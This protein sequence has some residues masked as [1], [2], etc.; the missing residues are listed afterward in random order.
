MFEGD[1]TATTP[2]SPVASPPPVKKS[3]GISG[4]R[5]LTLG[6][7]VFA[8][9]AFTGRVDVGSL[10]STYLDRPAPAAQTTTNSSISA[11]AAVKDVVERANQAQ[12][13][14]YARNDPTLM[15]ATATTPNTRSSQINQ[16]CKGS[17]ARSIE[18]TN[19]DW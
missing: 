13:Q 17:G 3:G 5:L 15:R 12:A 7:L 10:V 9:A 4:G 6:I 18:I 16:A 1:P 11:V 2:M 14:A 8:L 19:L